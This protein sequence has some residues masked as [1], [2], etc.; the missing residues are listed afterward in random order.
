MITTY[1]GFHSLRLS[2]A[3]IGTCALLAA[4]VANLCASAV[5]RSWET[6]SSV[7]V[8]GNPLAW[9]QAA[10]WKAEGRV[11]E[12]RPSGVAETIASVTRDDLEARRH[13]ER[14]RVR[15]A[16]A[17]HAHHALAHAHAHAHGVQ[18]DAPVALPAPAE[19]APSQAL[20]SGVQEA[21]AFQAIYKSL[22][23][24][25]TV[26]V[27]DPAVPSILASLNAKAP[28]EPAQV[29][30]VSIQKRAP[31]AA[32][33]RVLDTQLVTT[34]AQ[35]YETPKVSQPVTEPKRESLA[36]PETT[37]LRNLASVQTQVLAPAIPVSALPAQD[38]PTLAKKVASATELPQ[39][40]APAPL[41]SP[42]P[43]PVQN[44][45][46]IQISKPIAPILPA[47][48]PVVGA[49]AQVV[50]IQPAAASKSAPRLA[51]VT[52]GPV[53]IQTTLNSQK[54]SLTAA[55]AAPATAAQDAVGYSLASAMTTQPTAGTE[56][57]AA[58]GFRLVGI[59][60][61]EGRHPFPVKS[62]FISYEGARDDLEG[63]R[64]WL[65]VQAEGAWPT[66][67]FLAPSKSVIPV[68][69]VT[70]NAAMLLSAAQN[71]KLQA[72]SALVWGKIG[73]GQ[74][75]GFSGRSEK[76]I[77]LDQAD[78]SRL[79]VLF[80][81]APGA[82]LVSVDSLGSVA[83]PAL[84]GAATYLDLTQIRQVRLTGRVFDAAE[85][86]AHG[87][88][89]A[90]VR[91]LGQ[92]QQLVRTDRSGRF[93]LEGVNRFGDH[94][95]FLEVDGKGDFTHR[96][97]VIASRTRDLALFRVGSAQVEGWIR[98]LEGGV[99]PES[100]LVLAV[101]PQLVAASPQEKLSPVVSPLQAASGLVPETY[102]LDAED[103]L[104][105]ATPMSAQN[106]RTVA[107]QVPE[108][109]NL[110]RVVDAQRHT[111]W[112]ELLVASPGVINVLGPN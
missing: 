62:S 43:A 52:P 57:N 40:P 63:A 27:L 73:S 17:A 89:E 101:F 104:N 1:R 7:T 46:A 44:P 112:S 60:A 48:A 86:R 35:V 81:V 39:I 16:R 34:Q 69:V 28:V 22:Q 37:P 15:T 110:C 8:G 100:G 80:N 105:A 26:A 9:A 92:A 64:G 56:A 36:L 38:G 6:S 30:Q 96:Y 53:G 85:R 29:A 47:Q 61:F 25:F 42:I 90:T 59:E 78:G 72:S 67:A 91:V 3:G 99:S 51:Q 49:Q 106:S 55:P 58:P 18:A 33:S 24:R 41:R 87:V 74:R 97:R 77:Y 68:P 50:A 103:H 83:A 88:L 93:A 82:H 31:K 84:E 109:L 95:L 12:E 79:F 21:Q 107:V 45:V 94:P 20:D 71:V 76:A 4:G 102:V 75:V 54:P 66:V 5:L 23:N 111:L 98:Q 10:H 70:Q 32:P 13:R 14:Q 2:L 108:G 19:S 65:K 11:W